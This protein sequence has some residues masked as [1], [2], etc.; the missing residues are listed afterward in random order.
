MPKKIG[1]IKITE[2][3]MTAVQSMHT[4]I[5]DKLTGPFAF[6]PQTEKLLSLL[7]NASNFVQAVSK[8]EEFDA[9]QNM[10]ALQQNGGLIE[11]LT[12]P[13]PWGN[14]DTTYYQFLTQNAPEVKA[15]IDKGLKALNDAADFG[16]NLDF[17]AIQ[18]NRN[19]PQQNNINELSGGRLAPDYKAPQLNA[20]EIINELRQSLNIPSTQGRQQGGVERADSAPKTMSFDALQ[21][22][23]GQANANLTKISASRV[24]GLQ[25]VKDPALKSALAKFN[26]SR[27]FGQKAST[28]HQDVSN[29]VNAMQI[30]KNSSEGS[31]SASLGQV[32]D[33]QEKMQRTVNWMNAAQEMFYQADIYVNQKTPLTFAGRDRRNGAK[34]LRS[35]AAQEILAA[36][37]A[38]IKE[39]GVD[40]LREVYSGVAE[41]RGTIAQ[42]NMS[43]MDISKPAQEVNG[44]SVEKQVND[45]KHEVRRLMLDSLAAHMSKQA[46]ENDPRNLEGG[47]F[48]NIR[49]HLE[50]HTTLSMA[51]YDHINENWEN[52]AELNKWVQNPEQMIQDIK[53]IEGFEDIEKKLA[54]HTNRLE[55]RDKVMNDADKAMNNVNKEKNGRIMG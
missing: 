34:D 16:W 12:Q 44:R 8:Y 43:V 29:A 2:E 1:D 38:I 7:G 5:L 52:K 15:S 53:K 40:M 54:N 27:L 28:E 10:E 14:G 3:Q 36:E 30:L 25:T 26:T 19:A 41:Q 39:G 48:H 35:I 33:K 13:V 32:K 55:H 21:E 11:A 9:E 50:W 24:G 4:S 49:T 46:L 45:Q 47:N 37:N 31:L 22:K 42:K 17:N 6:G 18:A 20:G 23:L 51:I